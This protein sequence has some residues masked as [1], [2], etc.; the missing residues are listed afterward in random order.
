MANPKVTL[1]IA[2]DAVPGLVPAIPAA[3][4]VPVSV[5]SG[6]RLLVQWQEPGAVS[7]GP[8]GPT[9]PTG[10]TGAQGLVGNT[11]PTGANGTNGATGPTGPTGANGTNGT[12]GVSAGLHYA[13][14]SS[15]SM[16]DPSNGNFR[17]NNATVASATAMAISATDSDSGANRTFIATWD[18]SS[19]TAHRGYVLIRKLSAPG[20]FAIFDVTG[21]LTDNTTWLQLALTYVTGSGSFSAADACLVEFYRTGDTGATGPIGGSSGQALYN[22]AGVCAGFTGITITAGAVAGIAVGGA[23]TGVTHVDQNGTV[24]G[25]GF[26]RCT[27]SPGVL[28]SYI[29]HD[30]STVREVITVSGNSSTFTD[31]VLGSDNSST[32]N[33][34][35]RLGAKSQL[36]INIAGSEMYAADASRLRFEGTYAL[37][38]SRTDP[39]APSGG[40]SL[41]S[42]STSGLADSLIA[43]DKN[44]CEVAITPAAATA[45]SATYLSFQSK[46]ALT[47]GGGAQTALS[48]AA[49]TALPNVATT[50]T[51]YI[52][53]TVT[54]FD[55]NQGYAYATMFT[56]VA[57]IYNNAGTYSVGS[58]ITVTSVNVN[59]AS[60]T[61]LNASDLYT[62]ATIDISSGNIRVRITP[63]GDNVDAYVL[64][65]TMGP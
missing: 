7:I 61:S 43:K 37:F 22:N 38:D 45:T 21:A 53:A 54:L 50:K 2:N 34:T 63:A 46:T 52:T 16:A 32:G 49:A 55:N 44:S 36:A 14:A 48:V 40:V 57:P 41:W 58:N 4:R 39:S 19:T 11:G 64:L 10:A 47:G 26:I 65:N 30:A 27:I 25:S 56:I 5:M 3:G 42:S 12:N 24:A 33:S 1:D 60:G 18:D 8:T 51:A 59:G 29:A 15:T 35:L 13:F 17:L 23:L 28:L 20:T 62:A 31:I 9:G 6:G